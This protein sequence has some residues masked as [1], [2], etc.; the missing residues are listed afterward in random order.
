MTDLIVNL[1]DKVGFSH[2]DCLIE[3]NEWDNIFVLTNEKIANEYNPKKD[4]NFVIINSGLP[5]EKMT[6]EITKY[7]KGNVKG[8]EVALN[9]F[10]GTGK[11]HMAI[12]SSLLKIGLGIRFVKQ[13]KEKF[14]EL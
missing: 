14:E 6:E 9:I 3:K 10:S 5:T 11:E 4:V 7:L 1:T 2:I 13:G 12:L 8:F